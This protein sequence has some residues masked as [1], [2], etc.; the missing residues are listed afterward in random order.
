[1][2]RLLMET[3]AF[4]TDPA[5]A[6]SLNSLITA[7]VELLQLTP[8]AVAMH[9]TSFDEDVSGDMVRAAR[10]A[11]LL[12]VLEVDHAPA[13]LLHSLAMQADTVAEEYSA[14]Y[15]KL[16]HASDS[17]RTALA[18]S[19]MAPDPKVYFAHAL[20]KLSLARPGVLGPILAA[21]PVAATLRDV[22]TASGVVIA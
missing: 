18:G 2:S 5:R 4:L 6:A 3:P 19:V 13:L 16:A 20:S 14:A 10:V 12:P 8:S 22:V 7:I 17:H 9:A 1:M 21:A 15:A 11:M